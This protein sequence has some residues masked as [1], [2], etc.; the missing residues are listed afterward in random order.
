MVK[1]MHK[2]VIGYIFIVGIVA[3]VALPLYFDL[4]APPEGLFWGTMN[5]VQRIWVSYMLI[6]GFGLW[7]WMVVDFFKQRPPRSPVLW[8][9]VLILLAY[10]GAALYFLMVYDRRVA[11][12][13]G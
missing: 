7:I 2:R 11:T 3:I 5:P 8:G 10:V 4:V 9:F 13:Q 12:Q 1:P 6:S